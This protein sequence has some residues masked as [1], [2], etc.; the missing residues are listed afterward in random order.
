M[1]LRDSV[2]HAMLIARLVAQKLRKAKLP[3]TFLKRQNSIGG[4][5]KYI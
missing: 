4:A 3:S 5:I 1:V 2:R